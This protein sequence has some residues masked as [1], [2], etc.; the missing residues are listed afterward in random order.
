MV[1]YRTLLPNW[2]SEARPHSRRLSLPA[3]KTQFA[4]ANTLSGSSVNIM[5]TSKVTQP[6]FFSMAGLRTFRVFLTYGHLWRVQGPTSSMSINLNIAWKSTSVKS[7]M[8]LGHRNIIRREVA[9]HLAI[10]SADGE[11]N[12]SYDNFHIPPA[13]RLS[14]RG[15]LGSG[16]PLYG[17][18][19]PRIV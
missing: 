1:E 11:V 18:V 15:F 19:L 16:P 10:N 6:P 2:L 4:Q 13:R 17:I 5:A 7:M 3:V 8:T 12:T 14:E 9:L